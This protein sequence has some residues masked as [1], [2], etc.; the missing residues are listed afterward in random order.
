MN[1]WKENGPL[2]IGGMGGSGTRLVA[3]LC[4]LFGFFLGDDLNVSSDNLLYTLLFRRQSWFYQSYNNPIRIN[5]GL[6]LLEKLLLKRYS[7]SIQELWFLFYAVTDMSL[8]YRD[9]RNWSFKRLNNILRNPRFV[10]PRYQGWGWKEP[11]SYLLIESISEYF[12]NLKFIHTIRHGVDMAFSKNQRQLTAWG[13]FFNI[14]SPET[15]A[16]YPRAAL[17]FWARANKMVADI[18]KTLGEG[19]YMQINF[20]QLCQQPHKSIG[21]L[22]SFLDLDV[23]QD[24]ILATQKLP[25]IPDSLGRYKNH[26]LKQFDP[27]DL[28]IVKS[29]GFNI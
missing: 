3:E 9:E 22:V 15:K 21:D 8:H 24:T 4:S 20:D 19:K 10:D 27:E 18:G 28:I 1:S 5:T 29:F 26:D 16:D 23:D 2:V 11:N 17:K 7:L 25:R 14:P 13:Q 12:K 6:S